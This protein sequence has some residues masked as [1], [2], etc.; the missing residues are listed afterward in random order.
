MKVGYAYVPEDEG[1]VAKAT[2]KEIRVKFKDAVEVCAAIRGMNAEDAKKY[3][4]AVIDK[5]ALVPVKKA[6]LQSGHKIG[7]K[8]YGFQPIKVSGAILIVLKSAMA[9]A[10]FRGLD[11]K[12]C[13]ISSA[14]AL[15]GRK[16]RRMKP[17][18]RHTVFESHLTT[19]QI[20]LEEVEES[21]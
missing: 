17:K 4:E 13:I 7:M 14:V 3:L 11:V 12:N 15:R 21:E 10:E 9:N 5:K 2:G 6:K 16:M 1:F 8:P 20:F 18:G 19:I